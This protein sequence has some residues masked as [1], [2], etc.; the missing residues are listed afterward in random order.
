MSERKLLHVEHGE[1]GV[2]FVHVDQAG[3]SVNT[4]RSESAAE[5]D[6]VLAEIGEDD[7]VVA[8]I[9]ISKKQDHFIAGADIGMLDA[10]SDAGAGA[11]LSRLGQAATERVARSRVPIVAAIHGA[12]LG[13][14][15]E[16]ALACHGR[17]A[18][19]SNKT[20]LGLPEVQLGVLPGM[21]G[22]QR[23]PR[24]VGVQAALDLL[25]TGRQ[26]DA[27]RALRM[28][29]VDEVVDP[30]S[31]IH[32][33]MTYAR[34]LAEAKVRKPGAWHKLMKTLD[35]EAMK[36]L[37]LVD[38][39]L[40]RKVVFDQ[41][42][43]SV[44]A[45]TRGN[46]PAPLRILQ[47]M[48]LGFEHGLERGLSAEADAFGELVVTPEARALR[49]VYFAQQAAK[50]LEGPAGGEA[51]PCDRVAIIGAG[52]MGQGIANV[53]L[54]NAHSR[55][56]LK[57]TSR[58]QLTRALTSID[59]YLAHLVDRGRLTR[60]Q[61]QEHLHRLTTTTNYR[62][63]EACDIAIEAVFEDLNLKRQVLAEVEQNDT[64]RL[65]FASNTSAF[66]ISDI[67]AGARHPERVLGMHYF[68]PVEKMPLLEV[69][70]AEQ[71]APWVVRA[72]VALG[73]KQGKTVIV[74]KD[75]PGFYTTRI[76]SPYLNEAAH[77]LSE[78]HSIEEIDR[79][80]VDLGFPVGPFTLLDEI[81]ID[82]GYKVGKL[83]HD[84][85]G[86]RMAPPAALDQLIER[87]RLGR[88]TSRGFYSYATKSKAGRR[89]VDTTV[90]A[91]LG[92]EIPKQGQPQAA[93]DPGKANEPGT[94]AERCLLAMVNEAARCLSDGIVQSP[95]DGD[96]GAIFGLGFPAHLGG[97]FHYIRARTAR[98]V[99]IRLEE[100]RRTHG[101]RFEPAPRL[102]SLL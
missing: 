32:A 27:K 47:V 29:L 53:A 72:A 39:P 100:L 43:T 88:K 55:V 93:L 31:L 68:S 86:E 3:E 35:P 1:D 48:R 89:P 101:Q 15:L 73:K 41:A 42:E 25:L 81:G 67:A 45:K 49:H 77:A 13:G 19:L 22:T 57:E 54:H 23:L 84:A 83:L 21:G 28:G 82:V 96:V 26:L 20:K 63:I 12:C 91:E 10:V 5:F 2:V 75:G 64:G 99:V 76:L 85:F 65:I 71:T 78:G 6:R 4:L 69:V 80:L 44:M 24:L 7:T 8:V 62:G 51:L 11:Q 87:G 70:Q 52:L 37:A 90:Y 34:R 61:R 97:P 92:L 36:E 79:Q 33:A 58:E 60:W 59:G 9:L 38:N 102:S 95:D 94:I 66:C 17:I 18:T 56:R 14:G 98:A 46:Y 30:S 74:V 50:R 16:I 40:G